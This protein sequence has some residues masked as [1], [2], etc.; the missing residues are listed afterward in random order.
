MAMQYQNELWTNNVCFCNSQFALLD[1]IG[2][3]LK[4]H[5]TLWLL[6]T[7]CFGILKAYCMSYCL[8]I[9]CRTHCAY[10]FTVEFVGQFWQYKSQHNINYFTVWSRGL[11]RFFLL[12]LEIS[13]DF[14]LLA[15][16]FWIFLFFVFKMLP[17][18]STFLDNCYSWLDAQLEGCIKKK[19]LW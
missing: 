8:N 13:Q 19:F 18:N 11:Q 16:L 6:A 5:C 14:A 4:V 12:V 3:C 9:F 17:D 1:Y 15:M 10:I 7:A 2:F